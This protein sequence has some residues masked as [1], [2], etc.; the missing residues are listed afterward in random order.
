MITVYAKKFLS[1]ILCSSGTQIPASFVRV[2]NIVGND[3][4]LGAKFGTFPGSASFT[5]QISTNNNAGIYVGSGKT[6]ATE[7][8]YSLTEKRTTGL[9]PSTP[10]L[11]YGV[12]NSGNPY[13]EFLFT[14]TNTTASAIEIA[15]LGY[16]QT[17][18]GANS[19]GGNANNSTVILF[20]HTVLETPI[21]I[22]AND[23]AAIKY[24]IKAILS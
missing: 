6:P 8:D 12:D 7:N 3:F 10:T 1:L 17:V 22:P 21:T 23:S 11:S 5:L 16:A 13:T 24:R 15:E 2:K 4:F 18:T 9:T 14:L 20:D 19:E